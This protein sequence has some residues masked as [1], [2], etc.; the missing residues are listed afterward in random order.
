MVKYA[1]VVFE[2]EIQEDLL[3]E[4]MADRLKTCIKNWLKYLEEDMRS[5][6]ED[7][8]IS[9]YPYEMQE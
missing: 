4:K 7:V 5:A 3:P 6:F 9:E 1:R 2:V 8:E